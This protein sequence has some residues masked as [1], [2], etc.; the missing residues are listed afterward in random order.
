MPKLKKYDFRFFNV[1][2]PECNMNLTFEVTKTKI[3]PRRSRCLIFVKIRFKYALKSDR[4]AF[5]KRL[6]DTDI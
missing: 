1:F 3:I 4:K 6:T 5:Q 2:G